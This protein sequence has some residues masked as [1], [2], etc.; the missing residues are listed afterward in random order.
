MTANFP[1]LSI[2]Q[3]SRF[4][5]EEDENPAIGN[6]MEG[7]YVTTRPRFTRSP[8]RMITTGFSQLN[9]SDRTIFKQFW[10]DHMGSSLA[11][12]YTHP[13]TSEVILV[14]FKL[15][16]KPKWVYVGAGELYRWDLPDIP[17]EEV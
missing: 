16:W 3:D 12:F 8:R 15:G 13:T 17:L 4:F 1:T 7:G 2:G 10:K 11:F 5:E 6:E 14:R 9:E